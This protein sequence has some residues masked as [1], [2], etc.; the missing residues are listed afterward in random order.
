MSHLVLTAKYDTP[1]RPS[2]WYNK[3][4]KD[5]ILYYPTS[6]AIHVVNRIENSNVYIIKPNYSMN[7]ELGTWS[8]YGDMVV[9]Q[10]PYEEED[11]E[12]PKDSINVEYLLAPPNSQHGEEEEP[13]VNPHG[14]L[15]RRQVFSDKCPWE[16]CEG[17]L[18]CPGC[19]EASRMFPYLYMPCGIRLACPICHGWSFVDQDRDCL[20]DLEDRNYNPKKKKFQFRRNNVLKEKKKIWKNRC[21]LV[22]R[23]RELLGL[24]PLKSWE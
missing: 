11:L 23:R 22:E 15:I 3:L 10:R 21:R 2:A 12:D 8:L 13:L 1:I 4:R 20:Q 16:K 5:D 24:P 9:Y 19:L 17:G 6:Q 14:T 7:S 18:F